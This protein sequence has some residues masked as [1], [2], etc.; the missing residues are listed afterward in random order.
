MRPRGLKP[1]WFLARY[2]ALKRR[3]STLTAEAAVDTSRL[4]GAA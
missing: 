2:A 1:G 4:H 3:S